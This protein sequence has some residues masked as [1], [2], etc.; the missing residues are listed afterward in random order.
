MVQRRVIKKIGVSV[1][2]LGLGMMRLPTIDGNVG[3]I[4]KPKA[5]EMVD[6]CL[7]E[8]VNYFDTAYMYHDGYSADFMGEALS[9]RKARDSFMLANKIPLWLCNN[10]E[11][12]KSMFSDQFRRCQTDYF[13]FYLIHALDRQNYAKVEEYKAYDF[14]AEQKKTGQN[15]IP[16]ILLS[17]QCRV[18]G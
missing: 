9:A 7:S 8:G 2:L 15:K 17:R 18:V 10:E 4:D 12:M 6:Y 1:P 3:S 5:I 14:L 16:R 11:H 13:D